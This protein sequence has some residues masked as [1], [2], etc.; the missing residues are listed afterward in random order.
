MNDDSSALGQKIF[1]AEKGEKEI[2]KR[3]NQGMVNVFTKIVN[4]S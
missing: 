4:I 1:F 3:R 2:S